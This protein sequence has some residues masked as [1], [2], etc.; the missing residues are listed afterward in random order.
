VV[1]KRVVDTDWAPG[2]GK[3]REPEGLSW[4]E[5]QFG[6]P[7]VVRRGLCKEISPICGFCSFDSME[8][9]ELQ[10]SCYALGVGG[11][12][13]WTFLGGFRQFLPESGKMRGPSTS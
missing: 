4:G 8:V 9:A 10:L 5:Q 7:Y 13:F 6:R 2:V 3:G 1:Q 12:V 11:L